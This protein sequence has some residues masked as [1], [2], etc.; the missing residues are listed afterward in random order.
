[1]DVGWNSFGQRRAAHRSGSGRERVLQELLHVLTVGRTQQHLRLLRVA[2]PID[3][4]RVAEA[5]EARLAVVGPVPD[6]PIPPK[7]RSSANAW[8]MTSLIVTPPDAVRS[9]ILRAFSSSA[10]K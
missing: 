9:S 5:Q 7:G 8:V 6:A 2:L 4:P 1:M 3:R 10:P